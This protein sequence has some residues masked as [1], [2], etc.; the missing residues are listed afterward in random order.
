M[1]QSQEPAETR[2]RSKAQSANLDTDETFSWL[3]QNILVQQLNNATTYLST[4]CGNHTITHFRG[5]DPQPRIIFS[6][7]TQ[8]KL[9]SNNSDKLSLLADKHLV[10]FLFKFP[11]VRSHGWQTSI[12][13]VFTPEKKVLAR[14]KVHLQ[15]CPHLIHLTLK[16]L[17]PRPKT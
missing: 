13:P 2:P 8:A 16:R 3:T 9:S 12:D 17:L 10:T 15:F 7:L 14:V 4:L 1:V 6:R 5:T 11:D